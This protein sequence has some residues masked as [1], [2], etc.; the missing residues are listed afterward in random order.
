MTRVSH[1]AS[2]VSACAAGLARPGA[3]RG[4]MPMCADN[5]TEAM[6]GGFADCAANASGLPDSRARRKREWG[7]WVSGKANHWPLV[8]RM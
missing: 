2:V 7:C 5:C 4:Y 6:L 1:D 8:Y 3:R